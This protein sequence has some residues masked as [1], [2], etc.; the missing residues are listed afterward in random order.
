MDFT[1]QALP[2]HNCCQ[3]FFFQQIQ[4]QWQL[5]GH[6]WLP[7]PERPLW[8]PVKHMCTCYR[9]WKC[10]ETMHHCRP[11]CF[12]GSRKAPDLTLHR[13]VKFSLS[14]C[15]HSVCLGFLQSKFI[16]SNLNVLSRVIVDWM[17]FNLFSRVATIKLNLVSGK[18]QALEK[19]LHMGTDC[20]KERFSA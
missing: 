12:W 4:W 6:T 19:I 2:L 15:W 20:T 3:W 17:N 14:F 7:Q 16:P 13:S 18:Q 1:L 9:L 5:A 11:L 8:A 10:N